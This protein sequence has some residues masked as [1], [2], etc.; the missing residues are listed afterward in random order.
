MALGVVLISLKGGYQP[1]LVSFLFGN[2]LAI[3][4][5]DLII[6]S[7]LSILIICFLFY[8]HRNITLMAFDM[9]TA[10]MAGI[11]INLLQI[12]FYILMAV[13]VVLGL[14]ILGI[15]LVSALIII[16][17]SSAKLLSRSFRGL[18]I[19]SIILSEVIVIVGMTLSYYIDSPTGPM[20]VLVGTGV[21]LCVF[22]FNQL[23]Q[24]GKG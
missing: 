14:K 15:V 22:T 21:F 17:A 19:Q 8:N 7:V 23:A 2:I 16:P 24:G 1:D 20:I 5:T 3:R 4:P 6:I 18:I 11:R 10:Y 12:T 9:D 13:S